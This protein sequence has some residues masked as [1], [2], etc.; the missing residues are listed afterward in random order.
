MYIVTSKI[1]NC[2]WGGPTPY[3]LLVNG[4]VDLRPVN[5]PF[6]IYEFRGCNG[7]GKSTLPKLLIANDPNATSV[8][9]LN[10]SS[11]TYCPLFKTV[12]VGIYGENVNCGGCDRISGNDAIAQHI[13]DAVEYVEAHLDDAEGI[14]ILYEGIMPS[15][16]SVG[17]LERV[18]D[19]DKI[20]EQDVSV[21]YMNTPLEVCLER[22]KTRNEGKEF[23]PN[24]V[25]NKHRQIFLQPRLV[26]EKYPNV[27]IGV[28]ASYDV[29]NTCN[30]D[31]NQIVIDWC[32]LRYPPLE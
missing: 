32:Q 6:R 11:L 27:Q 31:K 19:G 8:V 22:I 24:L 16:S 18:I 26:R 17:V 15:T 10:K 21:I 20:T 28:S 7:S 3:P 5:K 4:D 30:Y 13:K 29:T 23:N 12:I 14:R 9:T 25:K 1:H 2:L